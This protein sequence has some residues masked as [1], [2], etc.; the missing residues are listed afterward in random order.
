MKLIIDEGL[1]ADLAQKIKSKMDSRHQAAKNQNDNAEDYAVYD[2]ML[3]VLR[4]KGY[5][6]AELNMLQRYMLTSNNY[7]GVAGADPDNNMIYDVALNNDLD[8][9][10]IRYLGRVASGS[11]KFK[12]EDF[13]FLASCGSVEQMKALYYAHTLNIPFEQIGSFNG[14]P[15]ATNNIVNVIRNYDDAGKKEDSAHKERLSFLKSKGYSVASFLLKDAYEDV[16]DSILADSI[17]ALGL[18]NSEAKVKS[19]I[20]SVAELDKANK[21]WN[22][23]KSLEEALNIDVYKLLGIDGNIPH[24]SLDQLRNKSIQTLKKELNKYMKSNS[25]AAQEVNKNEAN[26]NQ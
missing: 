12:K 17:V 20:Q 22:E 16:D 26:N 25:T 9:N 5:S 7:D 1:F 14:K 4:S 10:K 18:G 8:I 19:A 21:K 15:P 6:N 13:N 11:E 2:Q 3:D 23:S 24:Y